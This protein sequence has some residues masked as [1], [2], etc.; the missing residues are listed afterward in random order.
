MRMEQY[1]GQMPPLLRQTLET[2]PYI[3][4]GLAAGRTLHELLVDPDLIPARLEA[5]PDSEREVL[6]WVAKTAGRGV[7]S[8]EQLSLRQDSPFAGARI[9]VAVLRLVR[10]GWFIPLRKMWGES[11]C[12]IPPE[13]FES[14]HCAIL[15]D[16]EWKPD[17][18]PVPDPGAQTRMTASGRSLPF[19]LFQL[20]VY[21]GKHEVTLTQKGAIHKRHVQ[22]ISELL[23]LAAVQLPMTLP[24]ALQDL[25]PPAF[26]LVYDL[27]LRL[28]LLSEREGRVVLERENLSRW[29]ALSMEEMNRQ[30]YSLWEYVFLPPHPAMHHFA[31]FLRRLPENEWHSLTDLGRAMKKLGIPVTPDL[32]ETGEMEH[33]LQ[34]LSALGWMESAR[35]MDGPVFRW[36]TP[37]APAGASRIS[38]DQADGDAAAGRDSHLGQT[39]PTLIVQP[40]MEIIV[41]PETPFAVRWEL[42]C[43]AEQ[44]SAGTV[45]LYRLSPESVRRACGSGRSPGDCIEFLKR[46][47]LYELPEHVILNI[48]VW[49]E[50]VCRAEIV[51]AALLRCPDK[52]T[53]EQMKLHKAIRPYLLE[54]VGEQD[55]I[56]DDKM[57]PALLEILQ[58]EGVSVPRLSASSKG[59]AAY[60]RLVDPA[61]ADGR[62]GQD[63]PVREETKGILAPRLRIPAYAVETRIPAVEELYPSWKEIPSIWLKHSRAYHS[64]TKK[65]ILRQ[66]IDW[67]T[68]VRLW[69]DGRP[70]ELLPL[71]IEETDRSF[72]VTG[73]QGR[74]L[75]VF[76]ADS[77]EEMQ[78][79]LPGIN[80]E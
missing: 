58:R 53:A 65:M 61:G 74:E 31:V 4:E 77:W 54:S 60:P 59:D 23:D 29:L 14:L 6:A 72:R 8:A 34:A 39:L 10:K 24:Y 64:S 76:E 73:R 1:V 30:L 66:A 70:I 78:L 50:R 15:P 80:V 41:P 52:E 46:N 49:A 18:R 28:R 67:Q 35:T 33:W 16:R 44:K 13:M 26:A 17:I 2:Q 40:D 11:L 68:T 62:P 42:E 63:S 5:L 32:E 45:S 12:R 69:K 48:S 22:K 7:F 27:A 19:G 55:F 36:L 37:P 51:K 25:Y 3:R 20:L 47:S 43:L 9:K 56:I 57:L 71:S 75:A 21:I 79:V 38:A